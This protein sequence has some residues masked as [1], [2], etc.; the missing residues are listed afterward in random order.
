MASSTGPEGLNQGVQGLLRLGESKSEGNQPPMVGA[1]GDE[2][3]LPGQLGVDGTAANF[4]MSVSRAS[5]RCGDGK[6]CWE[7]LAPA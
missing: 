4:R 5:S 6:S 3:S 1:R 2:V 7:Q